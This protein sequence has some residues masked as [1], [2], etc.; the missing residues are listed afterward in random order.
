[1][2]GLV[3]DILVL[4]RFV[5]LALVQGILRVKV[6]AYYDYDYDDNNRMK[7]HMVRCV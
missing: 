5:F 6:K 1:M 2:P 3:Y 4:R 7:R